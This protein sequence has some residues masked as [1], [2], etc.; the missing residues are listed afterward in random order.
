MAT[1]PTLLDLYKRAGE[2]TIKGTIRGKDVEIPV[3]LQKLSPTEHQK[4]TRA[5]S[6]ARARHV[7]VAFDRDSDGYLSVKD[8][9]HNMGDRVA[10]IDYLIVEEADKIRSS[11]EAELAAEEEW[12][13]EGYLEGLRD[14]WV[15]ELAD[16]YAEDPEDSEAKRVLTELTRFTDQVAERVGPILD[17]L[18]ASYDETSIAELQDKVVE[19][20]IK[21]RGTAV[22]LAEFYRQQMFFG[23]RRPDDHSKRYFSNFDDLDQLEVPVKL[24][25]QEGFEELVVDST[26]GKGSEETQPSSDSSERPAPAATGAS[27]SPT[28]ATQ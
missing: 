12:S 25:L 2:K 15:E 27:S 21:N 8:E 17:D 26:V 6:A 14:S 22:W 24:Q 16:R 20:V 28:A 4:A 10:L 1:R 18:R 13:D 9:V 5:A 11:A 7:A 19:Q 3:W 23:T